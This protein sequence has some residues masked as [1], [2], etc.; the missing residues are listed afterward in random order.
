MMT[1]AVWGGALCIL[2]A[3]VNTALKVRHAKRVGQSTR[4]ALMRGSI[5]GVIGLFCLIRGLS[6][7]PSLPNDASGGASSASQLPR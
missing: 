5:L 3:G 6:S 1:Q 7:S 4:T 2:V